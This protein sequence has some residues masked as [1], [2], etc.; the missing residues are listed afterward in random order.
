[1]SSVTITF[2]DSP[3][4]DKVVDIKWETS[5]ESDA[6]SAAKALASYVIDH[7]QAIQDPTPVTDV[8]PKE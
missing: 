6:P 5:D 8:E 7:L 4:D 3:N 1:M 2:T